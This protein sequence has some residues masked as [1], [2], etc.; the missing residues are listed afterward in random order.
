MRP[1]RRRK[2]GEMVIRGIL[3]ESSQVL[4][5]RNANNQVCIVLRK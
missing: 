1:T 5:H 4:D 2:I 3:S